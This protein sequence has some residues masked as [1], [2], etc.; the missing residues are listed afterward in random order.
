VREIAVAGAS[1]RLRGCAAARGNGGAD[2]LQLH[3]RIYVVVMF[4]WGHCVVGEML[5]RASVG[6]GWKVGRWVCVCVVEHARER[7]FR[8]SV[9]VRGC[10]SWR[11]RVF[12]Q[13][14]SPAS[15]AAALVCVCVC[16][17]VCVRACVYVREW[18]RV[19]VCAC[20]VCVCLHALPKKKYEVS[21]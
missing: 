18:R 11:W 15:A 9:L 5:Y 4:G 12:S 10:F 3:G 19:C 7:P 20:G 6:G 1:V 14:L 16:V 8:P 2:I 17:C 13:V 21:S